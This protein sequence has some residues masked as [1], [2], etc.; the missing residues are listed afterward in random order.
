[1]AVMCS[2]KE[3]CLFNVSLPLWRELSLNFK[4]RKQKKFVSYALLV[5]ETGTIY[6]QRI[7]GVAQILNY[8]ITPFS[9]YL[10]L[11]HPCQTFS[12]KEVLLFAF[13]SVFRF[14]VNLLSEL[15]VQI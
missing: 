13:R 1:M 14:S 10:S 6:V 7:E 15:P 4:K 2:C 5:K 9:L 8:M 12:Q 3:K 11:L